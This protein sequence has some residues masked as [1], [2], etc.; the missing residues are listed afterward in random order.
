MHFTS[1][2]YKPEYFSLSFVNGSVEVVNLDS[3]FEGTGVQWRKVDNMRYLWECRDT[4]KVTEAQVWADPAL[5]DATVLKGNRVTSSETEQEY[6][7]V[8]GTVMKVP[9][10]CTCDLST[11]C[12]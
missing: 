8:D 4:G 5:L 3:P 6:F 11:P 1:T 7:M 12:H 10:E 2:N 9:V